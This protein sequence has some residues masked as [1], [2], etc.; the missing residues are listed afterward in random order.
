MNTLGLNEYQ[1]KEKASNMA[2]MI[3]SLTNAFAN[4]TKVRIYLNMT[5]EEILSEFPA[6]AE[7][8]MFQ[9]LKM[10]PGEDY[11]IIEHNNGFRRAVD[12]TA[13][14]DWCIITE[15]CDE[16]MRHM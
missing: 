7:P 2:K 15:I 9:Y 3:S 14:S 4:K 5:E 13:D 10:L 16:I 6:Y 12:I 11:A 1:V 8:V